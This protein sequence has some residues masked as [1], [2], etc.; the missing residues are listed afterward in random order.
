MSRIDNDKLET[1]IGGTSISGSIL[2]A[3][4]NL[5]SILYEA[6]AG[7]GSAIRR[8]SENNLCPLE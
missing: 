8:L 7:V 2:N 4:N 5:F 6:G 3:F 1:I